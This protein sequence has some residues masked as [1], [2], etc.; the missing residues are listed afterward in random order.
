[1]NKR[2]LHNFFKLPLRKIVSSFYLAQISKG[3]HQNRF[4]F[5]LGLMRSGS[6]LL[7]HILSTNPSIIGFGETH[8]TYNEF[9]DLRFLMA[10]NLAAMRWLFVR[11]GIYLDKILHDKYLPNLEVLNFEQLQTIFIL[12]EPESCLSNL[13]RPNWPEWST[14]EKA[15]SYYLSRLEMLIKYAEFI[16][17]SS[18]PLLLTY[19]DIICRTNET[20]LE[21]KKYLKIDGQLHE[22][23]NTNYKFYGIIGK[24]LHGWVDIGDPSEIL[25][26]GKIQRDIQHQPVDIPEDILILCKKKYD[27]ALKLIKENSFF[28]SNS[29]IDSIGN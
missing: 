24:I 16:N 6:S 26:S 10:R 5:I 11:K 9:N 17:S 23:Y 2:S 22:Q 8:I 13:M 1:M 7:A 25:R 4:I 28:L 21:L 15:S 14:I 18:K 20:L 19:D 27:E 12:R 29:C 3:F